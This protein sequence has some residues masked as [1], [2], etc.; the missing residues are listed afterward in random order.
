MKDK[1]VFLMKELSG[2]G[3]VICLSNFIF[4]VLVALLML[5]C[6]LDIKQREDISVE[7]CVC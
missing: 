4:P 3:F 6:C 5:P 7:K 1:V 2:G